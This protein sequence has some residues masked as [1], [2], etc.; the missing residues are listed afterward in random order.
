V[1]GFRKT[2]FKGGA[3]KGGVYLNDKFVYLKGFAQRASN[4][5]AG[6][7]G[8]YPDWLHDTT[9]SQIR[10]CHGNYIRWMHVAPQKVDAD[11]MAR[12]GILQI[13]P[14]GDK[15]RDA[16]GRQWEQRLEVMRATIVYYRNNPSILFWEAGNTVVTVEQM[17]Q[18]IALRK[19]WDPEGGRLISDRDNDDVAANSALT[20]VAEA[21]EVMIG[22]DAKTDALTGPDDIFRGYSAARRDRAPLIESEDFREEGAR[23]F[24][25]DDSPPYYKA[26]KGPN[27]TWRVR[28]RYLF[29]SES[30]ALAG[31]ERYWAYWQNRISNPDPAHSKWS[32][33]ASIYFSDS[34]ADGRQDS[35]EVCRVSGKVDAV[36]LPKQIYDAH[37]VMQNEQP[38]LHI[39]GHWTYPLEQPATPE[40]PLVA[41]RPAVGNR[42]ALPDLPAIPAQ[43]AHKTVKTVYVI[44][45][46]EEVELFL[47]GKSLGV[48]KQPENGFVFAFPDIAYV[49][50]TLKAVGRNA[51]KVVAGQE[52]TTAGQPAAI[53]LTPIVGPEGLQADGQDAALID[54]EVVDAKGQRCPTDD[55]RVDFTISGPGI[56]RG[57]YNSGMV[58]STNN[59]YLRT[60]CGVNRVAVRATLTPG[61]ITATATRPGLKPATIQ[62]A[63][64]AVNL[65]E[66]LS[67]LVPQ[68]LAGPAEG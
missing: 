55:D 8:A 28:S 26:K 17:Q 48:N 34:D 36:R 25:D 65:T 49:P 67:S 1:T 46:T 5:W 63:S 43:P 24:W 3:G 14:A 6:L 47:N 58:D 39:L 11:A 54:F 57:G 22:Q 44:A 51:A 13:C 30:F 10:A 2:E 35:S 37:R 45:N 68:L 20:P 23:R 29:T 9:A 50:G 40:E 64:K 18:M 59:L 41:G 60:E 53:K 7:G 19:Q 61:T 56:W 32:G 4:E 12:Y 52:L 31:I 27:D 21:Y 38:D 62:V 42:P 66:G 16:T 33:Y 15:E